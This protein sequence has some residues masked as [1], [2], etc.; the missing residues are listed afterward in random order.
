MAKSGHLSQKRSPPVMFSEWSLMCPNKPDI[1]GV[2][3]KSNRKVIERNVWPSANLVSDLFP[4]VSYQVVLAWQAMLRLT[5][6]LIS[7]NNTLCCHSLC[8]Q[9]VLFSM[10]ESKPYLA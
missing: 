3:I 4:M 8:R 9:Q 10:T 2:W 5:Q 7:V 6:K 1:L